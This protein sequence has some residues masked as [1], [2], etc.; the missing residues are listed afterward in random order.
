M[1]ARPVRIE[2]SEGGVLKVIGK[3]R[4]ACVNFHT[5]RNTSYGLL[6]NSPELR[7]FLREALDRCWVPPF[8]PTCEDHKTIVRGTGD[9]EHPLKVVACPDCLPKGTPVNQAILQREER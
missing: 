1:R 5:G 2:T 4:N 7:K 8:C 9:P 6:E 3:G